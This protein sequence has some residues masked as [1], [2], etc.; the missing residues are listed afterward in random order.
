[1][2]QGAAARELHCEMS[3]RFDMN[4]Y[5]LV[6][7][8]QWLDTFYH[9]QELLK[10]AYFWYKAVNGLL[11][12]GKNHQID[13]TRPDSH[14]VRFLD[15]P[16]PL[17][18]QLEATTTLVSQQHATVLGACNDTTQVRSKM[19]PGEIPTP[20]AIWPRRTLMPDSGHFEPW[21]ADGI[22]VQ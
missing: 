1:M 5:S 19:G 2:R 12:L 15:G 7:G 17:K 14:Y 10:G 22:P 21:R 6:L 11:W 9:S 13:T 3:E 18:L 20:G 8:R 4:G 16:G